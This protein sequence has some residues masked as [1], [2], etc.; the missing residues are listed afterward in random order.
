VPRLLK[1]K[2][3]T[4][5]HVNMSRQKGNTGTNLAP[6]AVFHVMMLAVR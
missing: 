1:E 6:E 3:K 2:Q 4:K 5:K